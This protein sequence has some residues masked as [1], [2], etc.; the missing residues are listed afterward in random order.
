MNF[1]ASFA[2]KWRNYDNSQ[3]G[4][5][6]CVVAWVTLSI[7]GTWKAGFLGFI[8]AFIITSILF[9]IFIVIFPVPTFKE[10]CDEF[11][12]PRE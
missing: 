2:N 6:I 7:V 12:N 9:I 3:R 11:L 4:S 8:F 1:L 10:S 5:F